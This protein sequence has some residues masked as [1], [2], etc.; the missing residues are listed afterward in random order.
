[1]TGRTTPGTAGHTAGHAGD[2]TAVRTAD[3]VDDRAQEVSA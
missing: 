3:T 1:M 2:D